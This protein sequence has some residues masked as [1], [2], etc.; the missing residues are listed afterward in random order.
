MESRD[1][2][3]GPIVEP[4]WLDVDT[5]AQ[6]LCMSRHALYHRVGRRQIPFTRQG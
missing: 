3:Q 6:Y 5:A 4:R 2:C 1:V